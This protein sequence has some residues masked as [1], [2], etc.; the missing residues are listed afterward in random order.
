MTER[1]R[2][3]D[4]TALLELVQRQTFRY[5]WDFGHPVSGLSR[6][7]S[8]LR[9]E[10]RDQRRHRLRRHGDHRRRRAGLDQPRSRGWNAC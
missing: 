6:D 9:P 5:F 7:R 3:L 1:P 10:C 8:N 2:D 4:D